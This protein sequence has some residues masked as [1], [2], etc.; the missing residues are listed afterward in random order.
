MKLYWRR[1]EEGTTLVAGDIVLADVEKTGKSTTVEL[2][3]E[4]PKKKRYWYITS[5]RSKYDTYIIHDSQISQV[6]KDVD[7]YNRRISLC[8][9]YERINNEQREYFKEMKKRFVESIGG[10][11]NDEQYKVTF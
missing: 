8:N 5:N 7:Y 4:V 2:C 1:F 3:G 9:K 10:D 11:I 6:N